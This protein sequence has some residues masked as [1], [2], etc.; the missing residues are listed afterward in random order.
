[1]LKGMAATFRVAQSEMVKTSAER[2]L[3]NTNS[4]LT[5]LKWVEKLFDKR[6]PREESVSKLSDIVQ[7]SLSEMNMVLSMPEAKLPM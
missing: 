4:V 7:K 6:P 1:M 5:M 3:P 2:R